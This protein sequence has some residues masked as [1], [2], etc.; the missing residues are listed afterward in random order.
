MCNVS[1]T[2]RLDFNKFKIIWTCQ[3]DKNFVV[4]TKTFDGTE[5]NAKYLCNYFKKVY[6]TKGYAACLKE[7]NWITYNLR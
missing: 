1:F 7:T 3:N 4:Y 5:E 2:Y 6:Y